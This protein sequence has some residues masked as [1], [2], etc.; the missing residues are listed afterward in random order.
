MSVVGFRKCLLEIHLGEMELDLEKVRMD[1][2][3]KELEEENTTIDRL[4]N[5][6]KA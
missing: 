1:D 6:L 3:V 2:R 4:L 5:Q